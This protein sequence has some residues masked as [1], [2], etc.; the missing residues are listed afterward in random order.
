MLGNGQHAVGNDHLKSQP[1]KNIVMQ[2]SP[3]PSFDMQ[4]KLATL[5]DSRVG[6]TALLEREFD[7]AFH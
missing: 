7:N 2:R 1:Y 3:A 6:K 5:G 4:I